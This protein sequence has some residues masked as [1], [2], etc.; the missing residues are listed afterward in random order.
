MV[1]LIS[2]GLAL[3]QKLKTTAAVHPQLIRSESAS[4]I[5]CL[6][7]DSATPAESAAIVNKHQN[8]DY[9]D[10]FKISNGAETADLAEHQSRHSD[11]LADDLRKGC[12]LIIVRNKA[13]IEQEN[14]QMKTLCECG[15]R[16]PFCSCGFYKFPG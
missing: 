13:A 12:G 6:L 2:Y 10:E 8:I 14:K 9:C 16:P 1:D 5:P 15:Y 4:P 11:F 3:R 7:T